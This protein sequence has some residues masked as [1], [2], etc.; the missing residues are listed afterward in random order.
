[1]NNPILCLDDQL[2]IS[3][4]KFNAHIEE[5]SWMVVLSLQNIAIFEIIVPRFSFIFEISIISQKQETKKNNK[6]RLFS[7]FFP[8]F[9]NIAST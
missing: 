5:K 2:I 3:M 9:T 6:S 4:S 1:M 8:H 7:I